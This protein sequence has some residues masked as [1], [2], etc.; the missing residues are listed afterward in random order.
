MSA[1]WTQS[2]DLRIPPKPLRINLDARPRLLLLP[3]LRA[4][5][6]QPVFAAVAGL[7]LAWCLAVA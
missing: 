4:P 1:T 6:A 3:S 5:M 2:D 7:L